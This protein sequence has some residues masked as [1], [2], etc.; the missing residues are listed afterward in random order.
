[1]TLMRA[2]LGA[3]V[4]MVALGAGGIA[5]AAGAQPE[6][7]GDRSRFESATVVSGLSVVVDRG[8]GRLVAERDTIY[9]IA[10]RNRGEDPEEVTI[11][12]TVPPWMAEA[13]PHDGGE[14][15]DGFVDWPVTLAPGEATVRQLTGAYAPP[16][17]DAPSRVALTACAVGGPDGQPIVCATDIA[18]LESPGSGSR[19]WLLAAGAAVLAAAAAVAAA[20]LGRRRRARARPAPDGS[21]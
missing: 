3:V 4:G 16:G 9:T 21:G 20:V 15:R 10:V 1:M 14:V 8:A 5:A 7:E 19:W 13:R 17:R 12:V 11:R 18:P 6:D 2:V